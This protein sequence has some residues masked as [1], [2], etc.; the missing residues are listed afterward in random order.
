[1]NGKDTTNWSLLPPSSN[2]SAPETQN[3]FV[4]KIKYYAPIIGGVVGALILGLLIWLACS[5]RRKAKNVRYQ[6]LSDPAPQG[7][8]DLHLM[9]NQQQQGNRQS[10][11]PPPEYS[12]ESAPRASTSDYRNPWDPRY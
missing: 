10:R 7:A 2:G 12:E 9:Q 11:G 8:V 1:M 4:R 6:P 3:T 5:R